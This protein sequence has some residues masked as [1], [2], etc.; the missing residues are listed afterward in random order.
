MSVQLKPPSERRVQRALEALFR[1]ARLLERRRRRRQAMLALLACGLLA[2]VAY[3]A[4]RSTDD[5]M[6]AHG[7]E[8]ASPVGQ[9]L[10][11]L[12]VPEQPSALAVGPDGRLYVADDTRN[13]ILEWSRRG[14]FHVIAGTGRAGFS[15]DRGAALEAELD[16]PGGM[17]VAPD[18]TLYFADTGNGRIRAISPAGTITTIA[19]RARPPH[20]RW[21]ADGT[22]AVHTALGGPNDVAIGPDGDLYFD[23]GS[24][25]ILRLN[26]NGTLSVVVGSRTAPLG[27]SG[28]GGPATQASPDEPS[29]LAFDSHGDLFING[30]NTRKLLMVTPSGRITLPIGTTSFYPRGQ[31]GMVTTSTGAVVAMDNL[32]VVRLT[33]H[34]APTV[35]NLLAHRIAHVG[36]FEPNG[37]AVAP[38]GGFYADTSRGNG[39]ARANA[40]AEIKRNGRIEIL[41]TS[42]R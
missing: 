20:D 34:S 16:Q 17:T 22:E 33:P 7:A 30:N 3:L 39:F 10:G 32:A 1:E 36:S 23:G 42:A 4:L 15:G 13:E 6:G 14:T 40:L 12:V 25:E 37:I 27:I 21:V 11:A 38:D 2:A 9:P 26:G 8:R 31:G 24:N 29:G 5:S 41:W 28:I 19:G 18:G 35:A